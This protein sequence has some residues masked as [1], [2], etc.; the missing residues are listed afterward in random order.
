MHLNLINVR[1]RALANLDLGAFEGLVVLRHDS[2]TSFQC[3]WNDNENETN[4]FF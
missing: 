1:G 2:L 3:H 4:L